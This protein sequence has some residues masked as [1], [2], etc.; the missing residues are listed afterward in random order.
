MP[1][2]LHAH[3]DRS[4]IDSELRKN[5]LLAGL[6]DRA[7]AELTGLLA[8]DD[9]HR[10]AFLLRQGDRELRHYFVLDGLLKRVVASTEGKELTLRFAG[11][12]DMET[13]YDA[14]RLKTPSAYSVTCV[15]K[16]RVASL[17][18]QEWG[19]FLDR[20]AKA[21]QRFEECVMRVTSAT[22]GHA[23]TL[24]LL[25]APGRVRDFACKH[26]ELNERLPQKEL[27]SYLN[28]SAETLCRLMR[29]RS[30]SAAP[31][32]RPQLRPHAQA[33]A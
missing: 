5:L 33:Q 23:I 8:V 29:R 1:I 32:L 2:S 18:M 9:L 21:K 19:D 20:H 22:M 14:W 3:P 26:P 25:D 17:P 15:T 11:E 30:S 10:G 6:D 27:A 31:S 7:H 24:H 13:S 28:L 12:R 4:R 16:A